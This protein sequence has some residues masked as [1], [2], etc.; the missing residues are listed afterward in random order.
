[1]KSREQDIIKNMALV[2]YVYK[3]LRAD[4]RGMVDRDDLISAGY[5]GLIKA[6]DSFNPHFGTQFSTYATAVIIT[7]MM[8]EISN[9][10]KAQT[11]PLPNE[12][13]LPDKTDPSDEQA[14]TE[15]IEAMVRRA[16]NRLTDMERE[17]ITSRYWC[18]R[19]FARSLRERGRSMAHQIHARALDE[20]Y[21]MLRTRAR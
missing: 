6:V 15:E 9:T 11:Q 14:E 10:L 21:D 16:V 17:V 4:L 19:T 5:C 8:E 2:P 12:P 1:M 3:S 7:C 18:N 20:L 13:N